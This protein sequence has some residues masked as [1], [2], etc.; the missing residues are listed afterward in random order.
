MNEE[1]IFTENNEA[2]IHNCISFCNFLCMTMAEDNH[3]SADKIARTVTDILL[4]SKKI[5]KFERSVFN[6]SIDMG[7]DPSLMIACIYLINFTAYYKTYC[8]SLNVA[9]K[10]N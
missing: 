3:L 4:S 10:T 7:L 8:D 6:K 5:K 9:A 2:V 1:R